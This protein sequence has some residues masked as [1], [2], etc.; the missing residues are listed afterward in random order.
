LNTINNGF[1]L[2]AKQVSNGKRIVETLLKG[3][4]R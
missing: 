3:G 4:S 1:T 2:G